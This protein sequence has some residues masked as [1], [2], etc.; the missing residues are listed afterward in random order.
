VLPVAS[1]WE[2][3]GLR[4]GFGIDQDACELVAR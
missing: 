4:V 1:A 3:E 2:R